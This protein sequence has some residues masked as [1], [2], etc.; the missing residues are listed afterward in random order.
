VQ[1]D[2]TE[3]SLQGL[4][5]AQILLEMDYCTAANVIIW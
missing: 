3:A 4:P 1:S 5:H 2:M